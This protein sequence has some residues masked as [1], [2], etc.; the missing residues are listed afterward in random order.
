M[1]DMNLNYFNPTRIISGT[2]CLRNYNT[3]SD[4]GKR[5]FIVTG[6]NSGK[7]SGALDDAIQ[8]LNNSGVSYMIF[9]EVENNPSTE[10]C[11]KA[12][13]LAH[14]FNASFI[15]GIG[16]G[17]P[18][19][20]AKAIAIY[21]ANPVLPIDD[22]FNA[23]YANRPLPI[24]AV[25]TT[26]GTG[27][28]V[29][30]FS[31]L[32]VHSLGTKKGIANDNLFPKISFLD[33]MHAMSL[34]QDILVSTAI[35]AF[36]HAIEGYFSRKATLM[37]NTY[38]EAAMRLLSKGLM[39]VYGGGYDY[40]LVADFMYASTLAGKVI[41]A[42]STCAVH[43]MGYSLTYHL[44]VP[45][46]TANAYFLPNFIRLM[47]E[48]SPMRVMSVL[49]FCNMT[50]V[51]QLSS[52]LNKLLPLDVKLSCE[53]IEQFSQE[54][55]KTAHVKNSIRPLGIDEVRNLYKKSVGQ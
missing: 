5:C 30:P 37:T 12:G 25:N 55:I 26:V 10:T 35:D 46:G 48:S 43:S 3:F 28:E 17:S 9:D 32:T 38:A 2:G 14:E 54:V 29:T 8:A 4:I 34:P 44:G 33:P 21:A 39:T 24:V 47:A 19:D 15:M 31:I 42:T 50:S 41:S 16:G 53:Q 18:I 22:I 11:K 13:N 23:T 36:S 7:K 20:A 27:S 6:K 51:D 49:K 1:K 45:H 52:L 40:D